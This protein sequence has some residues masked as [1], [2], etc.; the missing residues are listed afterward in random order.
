[1]DYYIY[2]TKSCNLNCDY[3]CENQEWSQIQGFDQ[4]NKPKYEI[5]ELIYFILKNREIT[6]DKDVQ[7]LFYGGEP[8]LNQSWIKDF[9]KRT[10][11]YDFGYTLF[12]NG[13]LLSQT[14]KYILKKIDYL[15]LS[16]DGT[17]DI[18][19][20]FRGKGNYIRVV[21]NLFSIKSHFYGKTLAMMT[22]TPYNSI[23][24]SVLNLT[25]NFDYIYWKL[26]SSNK[27]ENVKQFKRSY[28]RGLDL[29]I[30]YWISNLEQG[31]VKGII[32][33]L[34][35]TSSLLGGAKHENFRCNCGDILVSIDTDGSCYSCDEL[36]EDKF[37][38]GSI[39]G[40]INQKKISHA[41][42]CKDCE[43]R[44][45]CGGRCPKEDLLLPK[46]VSEFHCK[47][48]KMLIKKIISNLPRVRKLIDKGLIKREDFD[49]PH[50][51]SE[52]P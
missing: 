41:D 14:D 51:T 40:S 28:D 43:Y 4:V 15:F 24:E 13:T 20:R 5:S 31:R 37:K 1:M 32:P 36:V 19:D 3:C 50:M 17:E 52:I 21:K 42:R 8:L 45:V 18:N 39:Y 25:E 10:E 12:T 46:E 6:G 35:I 11:E 9:I 29:L 23:Y 7:I 16:I 30:D 22:I 34:A 38:I 48:T 47:L 26:L 49:F 27:L 44:Y 33:F 2:V